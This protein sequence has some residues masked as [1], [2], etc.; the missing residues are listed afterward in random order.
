MPH[1]KKEDHASMLLMM[2]SKN[3]PMSIDEIENNLF[4][5]A[6]QFGYG[7]DRD[8]IK[9]RKKDKNHRII[10]DTKELCESL[11]ERNLLCREDDIYRI[12]E[13]GGEIAEDTLHKIKR[14]W[15]WID[16]NIIS[17]EAASKNTVII[18]AFLALIKL[19]AGFVSGSIALI[20]DGTDAAVDTVS[21]LVV[22]FSVK[23]K[24]EMIGTLVI[25]GMMFFTSISIGINSV[26]GILKFVKGS[27]EVMK[28]PELVI[29]VEI[30]ALLFAM[31]L[32]FYQRSVGKKFRNFALISQSVDSKNHIYVSLSVISGAIFSIF[33]VEI[34][35]SIIGGLIAV[36]I[37]FDG[38]EL[39]KESFS[40]INGEEIN[41]AKYSSFIEKKWHIYGQ[42]TFQAYVIYSLLQKSRMTETEII[43]MLEENFDSGYIPI[44]S[45]SGFGL[46]KNKDFKK[47]F[48]DI[49]SPLADIGILNLESGKYAI[50]KNTEIRITEYITG[51]FVEKVSP[52]LIHERVKDLKVRESFSRKDKLDKASR[53]MKEKEKI[54]SIIKGRFENKIYSI[55]CTDE[56]VL[57]MR[58]K[59]SISIYLCDIT[60]LKE[61]EGKVSTMTV[62][63]FTGENHYKL[64]YLSRRKSF[65]FI[66]D[67]KQ[68]VHGIE[69]SDGSEVNLLDRINILSKI[70]DYLDKKLK[71]VQ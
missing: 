63:I 8:R 26:D 28:S 68:K 58:H 10:T 34:A 52:S 23:F 21:A 54:S 16:R 30:V 4:K 31:L 29:C 3:G 56:R 66:N 35:D 57:L 47:D 13:K 36:R 12:T 15:T 53:V 33:G 42:R 32:T 71:A 20:A 24:N 27:S 64:D 38:F 50:E 39:L 60:E 7:G 22:Y 41:F 44:L 43:E 70:Q 48:S 51:I 9:N 65:G 5:F 25:I 37:F 69:Y 2:I 18:D 61:S 55:M 62:E 1:A 46:A 17:P 40:S 11:V 59:E 67:L 49:V 14:V 6:S 45:E 19:A